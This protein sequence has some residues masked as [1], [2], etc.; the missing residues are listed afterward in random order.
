MNILSEL[1]NNNNFL[2][3]V[4]FGEWCVLSKPLNISARDEVRIKINCKHKSTKYDPLTDHDC[5]KSCGEII[6]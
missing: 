4:N 2:V 5:C 1:V 3:K 6:K